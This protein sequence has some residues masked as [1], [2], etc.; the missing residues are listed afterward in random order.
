MIYCCSLYIRNSKYTTYTALECKMD[1][2]VYKKHIPRKVLANSKKQRRQHKQKTNQQN[3][4]RTIVQFSVQTFYKNRNTNSA[5][6]V[7]PG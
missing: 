7:F 4:K 1:K 5:S 2:N 3:K 6:I